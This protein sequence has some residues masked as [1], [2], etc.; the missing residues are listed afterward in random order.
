MADYRRIERQ[1]VE[2]LGLGRRPIA[3][4]YGWQMLSRLAAM[5]DR[6]AA[7]TLQPSDN[8]IWDA[9]FVYGPGDRWQEPVPF[10]IVWGYPIMQ[11]R[12]ELRRK[13]EALVGR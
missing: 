13:V 5:I 10:P 1:L 8:A 6:R 3:V 9:F 2:P 12:D 7:A 4:T 11:T